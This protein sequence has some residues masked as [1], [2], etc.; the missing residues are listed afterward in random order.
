MEKHSDVFLYTLIMTHNFKV[1]LAIHQILKYLLECDSG[2]AV[3]FSLSDKT[4]LKAWRGG[5]CHSNSGNVTD[6]VDFIKILDAFKT[7]FFSCFHPPLLP[8]FILQQYTW[9]LS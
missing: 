1:S 8:P 5:H 6:E 3:C 7:Y 9:Y 2:A 4:S